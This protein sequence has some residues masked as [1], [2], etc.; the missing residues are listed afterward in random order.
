VGLLRPYLAERFLV[1]LIIGGKRAARWSILR[2]LIYCLGSPLVPLVLLRRL[3]PVYRRVRRRHQLPRGV[4]L[5]ALV[6]CIAKAV[7]EML[8][9]IIGTPGWTEAAETEIEINRLRYCPGYAA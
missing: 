3:F 6:G 9:Y 5:V 4:L 7:G 8:A 2:R 1:G